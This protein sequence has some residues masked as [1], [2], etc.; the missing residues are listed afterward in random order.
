M[1]VADLA[2]EYNVIVA[3]EPHAGGEFDTPE[4]A[5]WLM[6]QTRHD[7]LKLNFDISHFVCQ[8]ID[9]QRSVDL[10]VP[11]AVHTHVKDGYMENGNVRYQLPG[12]GEMDLTAY[13]K[14]VS[15]AG[16]KV[17]VYVEV[18]QQLS[19]LA[20]YDP[21]TTAERCFQALDRARREAESR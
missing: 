7:Y 14:V 12:D 20:G 3:A 19:M 2:G 9:L 5:V 8:G 18:S 4:K 1:R 13:M 11:Y 17:P 6:Q 15:D 10:C 21:W 16:L